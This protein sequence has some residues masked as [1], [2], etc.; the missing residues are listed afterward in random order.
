MNA[1]I[2]AIKENLQMIELSFSDTESAFSKDTKQTADI[3]E[4]SVEKFLASLFPPTYTV[5]KGKIYNISSESS[6]IDCV[7]LHPIHPRFFTPKR[8]VILAEGVYAAIE[9]KPD[10]ATLTKGSEFHR[11]LE[12]LKSVKKLERKISTIRK[13]PDTFHK[14]PTVMFSKKSQSAKKTL[15]YIENQINDGNISPEEI[16]DMIVVLNE[17]MI[18]HSMHIEETLFSGWVGNIGGEA[19]ILIDAKRE[20]LEVFLL[21]LYC[22]EPPEPPLSDSFFIKEYLKK[23]G[24]FPY[25]VVNK[26]ILASMR[27]EK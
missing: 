2:A 5:K 11:G 16:P 27:L 12:Q 25:I 23:A 21:A 1:A 7:I 6:E 22:F 19:Y 20:T 8:E 3:R 10:I 4:I 17:Y 9:V 15:K 13:I 14:I 18:F 24:Q 26:E